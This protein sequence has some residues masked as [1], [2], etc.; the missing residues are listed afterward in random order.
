MNMISR[1]AAVVSVSVS[2]GAVATAYCSALE[3]VV[4]D[5][6][7]RAVPGAEIR[8]E[9]KDGGLVR[10]TR[11]KG[12]GHYIQGDLAAGTYRVS[13]IVNGDTKATLT[14]VAPR[15]NE[16]ETLN[17]SLTGR[18]DFSSGGKHYVLLKSPTGT[19][20]DRWV[21]AGATQSQMSIGMQE[22]S[23]A[24]GNNWVRDVQ[25]SADFVRR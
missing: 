5:A 7:G 24:S 21:E 17:F 3:G 1:V 22:R 20:L 14:N 13:L 25:A 9:K 15:E 2:L 18:V 23:N 4:N 16:T 6:N 19:H 11:T 12:N 8:I 10:Q